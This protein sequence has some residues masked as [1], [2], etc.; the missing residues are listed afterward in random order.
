MGV[1]VSYA[2][3]VYPYFQV[4]TVAPLPLGVVDP[5]AVDPVGVGRIVY[6]VQIIVI[7]FS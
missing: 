4:V 5:L 7:S 6:T 2:Y 1:C 3:G